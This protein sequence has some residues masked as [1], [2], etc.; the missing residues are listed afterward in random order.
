[1]RDWM[2]ENCVIY[3]CIA[4]M[5]ISLYAMSHSWHSFW[6]FMMLCLVNYQTTRGG[7]EIQKE[8]NCD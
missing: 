7:H 6:S 1:M 3:V 2:L 5:V 8:A 4:A